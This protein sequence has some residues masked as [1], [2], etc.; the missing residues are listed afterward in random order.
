MSRKRILVG[1]DREGLAYAVG[2]RRSEGQ[3]GT[4]GSVAACPY[5]GVTESHGVP[6]RDE[7]PGSTLVG[8][9]RAPVTV[10]VEDSSLQRPMWVHKQGEA[11]VPFHQVIAARERTPRIKIERNY[12]GDRAQISQCRARLD[13]LSD[14]RQNRTRNLAR[15]GATVTGTSSGMPWLRLFDRSN[16]V[17][18]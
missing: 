17:C 13:P 15:L 6:V 12:C 1:A 9:C 10:G 7:D 8:L 18:A 16:A 4:G 11:Q 2:W 14:C 3:V 5:I